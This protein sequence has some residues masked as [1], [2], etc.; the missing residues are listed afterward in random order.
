MGFKLPGKSIQTGTSGHSSALKMVT[1]QR[2]AS[3]LK[4]KASPAKEKAYGGDGKTWQQAQ[5]DSGGTLNETTKGQRAYEKEMKAKDP[6]WN[7]REDNKWKKTQNKINASVGSKKVYDTIKENKTK[8]NAAGVETVKGAGFNNNKTLPKANKIK[9]ETNIAIE[10]DKISKAKTDAKNAENPIE[11]IT[12]NRTKNKSQ[13]NKSDIK[14]GR[15]DKYTGTV[16]SRTLNKLKS[17]VR[18]G[19]IKRKTKRLA[20]KEEKNNAPTAMYDNKK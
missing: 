1:E 20:K 5:K 11:R 2:A 13:K 14:S 9:E 18:E 8:P 16:V 7:K 17:K 15:D 4:M 10:N 3:A 12:A 6:K 19:Q